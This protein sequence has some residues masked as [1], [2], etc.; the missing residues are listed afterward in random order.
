[1]GSTLGILSATLGQ[2]YLQVM[3]RTPFKRE[4]ILT[5]LTKSSDHSSTKS[6]SYLGLPGL[7]TAQAGME[8]KFMSPTW[9]SGVLMTGSVARVTRTQLRGP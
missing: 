4:G 1:M 8:P 5:G 2:S 3:D 9:R 7:C 6:V